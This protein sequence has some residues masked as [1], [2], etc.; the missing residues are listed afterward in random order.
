MSSFLEGNTCVV[1]LQWG[2]EGKGKIVDFI[3]EKAD[4]VV[5]YCGGV[6]ARYHEL[7]GVDV[8]SR[9]SC[10]AAPERVRR[11]VPSYETDPDTQQQ[12]LA[13]VRVFGDAHQFLVGGTVNWRRGYAH[14]QRAIVLAGNLAARRPRHYPDL[15]SNGAVRFAVSQHSFSPLLIC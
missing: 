1:G 8:T 6:I 10:A 14:A 12:R 11:Y 3:A 7:A 4:V 9:A 5:R 2:D 15:K 13:F